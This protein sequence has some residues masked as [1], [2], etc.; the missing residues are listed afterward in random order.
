MLAVPGTVRAVV[1]GLPHYVTRRGNSRQDVFF[2]D[3]D[4]TVDPEGSPIAVDR[5]ALRN[6]LWAFESCHVIERQ[7]PEDESHAIALEFTYFCAS[8]ALSWATLFY[9]L[10]SPTWALCI[11][12]LFVAL[13]RLQAFGWAIDKKLASSRRPLSSGGSGKVVA[14]GIAAAVLDFLAVPAGVLVINFADSLLPSSRVGSWWDSLP[15]VLAIVL[16]VGVVASPRIL[17]RLPW[18]KGQ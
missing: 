3:G 17:Y 5:P 9:L 2:A 6:T 1:P 18:W 11:G 16:L 10:R 8:F 12:A 15:V 14:T 7:L 13:L 4:C